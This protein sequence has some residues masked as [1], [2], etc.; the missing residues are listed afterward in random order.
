MHKIRPG[1]GKVFFNLAHPE[2]VLVLLNTLPF[3][4]WDCVKCSD[5]GVHYYDIILQNLQWCL[6]GAI[7]CW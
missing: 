7:L 6:F 2:F 1:S 3:Q 4:K 5:F